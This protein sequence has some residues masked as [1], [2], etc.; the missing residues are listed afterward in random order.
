MTARRVGLLLGLALVLA[1]EVAALPRKPDPATGRI[2]GLQVVV[3]G[4]TTILLVVVVGFLRSAWHDGRRSSTVIALALALGVVPSLPAFLL[5]PDLVPPAAVLS[6]VVGSALSVLAAALVLLDHGPLLLHA[7]TVVAVVA[8]YA[9]LGVLV[10]LVLPQE[11]ERFGRTTAA[12]VMALVYAPLLAAIRR[13]VSRSIRGVGVDGADLARSV[14]TTTPGPGRLE[15]ALAAAATTLGLDGL[16]ID[17]KLVLSRDEA[18]VALPDGS[19]LALVAS[20]PAGRRRLRRDERRALELVALTAAPLVTEQRLRTEVAQARADLV[21]AREAERAQMHRELHDGLGPRLAG[22]AMRAEAVSR[23]SP[24]AMAGAAAEVSAEAREAI[25][26]VR[27]IVR[28]LRPG[29]LAQAG[30]W[31]AVRRLTEREGVPVTLPPAETALS[32]ASEVAFLRIVAEALTNARRHAPGSP[33][34]VTVDLA[35]DRLRVA[36]RTHGVAS[37]GSAPATE[38]FGLRSM[39]SRAEDVGGSCRAGLSGPDWLVD[40][41]LPARTPGESYPT[42][43]DEPAAV[44]RPAAR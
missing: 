6:A 42:R 26:E 39:R 4:F 15:S 16:R 24:E 23:S 31:V 2:G 5:P 40:V 12:A 29:D 36:V 20:L 44:S 22:L 1:A 43:P 18:S 34:T 25:E 38:G 11:A 10:D 17:A 30:I 13:Q 27:R 32:A 37:T 3:A 9:G 7:L 14:A 35:D 19:G 33:T 41:D 28:G 8:G 21:R